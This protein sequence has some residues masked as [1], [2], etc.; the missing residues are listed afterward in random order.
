MMRNPDPERKIKIEK[1][2][3]A[4]QMRNVPFFPA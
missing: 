3:E 2:R 4:L 1:A